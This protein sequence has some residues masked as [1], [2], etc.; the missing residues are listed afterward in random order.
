M[1]D[2]FSLKLSPVSNSVPIQM[3]MKQPGS[4]N[5]RPA[6]SYLQWNPLLHVLKE[7]AKPGN[8]LNAPK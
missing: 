8:N 5:P 3:T 1:L 7:I 2:L 6:L 4:L